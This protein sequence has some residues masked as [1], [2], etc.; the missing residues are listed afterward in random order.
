MGILLFGVQLKKIFSIVYS[1][2]CCRVLKCSFD[3]ALIFK[4]DLI[5]HNIEV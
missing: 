4:E 3:F 5:L 2:V 1:N